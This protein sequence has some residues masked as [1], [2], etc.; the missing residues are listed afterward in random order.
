MR[1]V[2]WC[3]YFLFVIKFFFFKLM[4]R[5]L[6]L[7]FYCNCYFR[8]IDCGLGVYIKKFFF[9]KVVDY[10]LLS[11]YNGYKISLKLFEI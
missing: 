2:D 10:V 9:L 5:Y 6:V 4:L 3:N 7:V 8:Y 11:I 1:L